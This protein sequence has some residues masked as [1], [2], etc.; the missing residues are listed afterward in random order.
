[1]P[2]MNFK[3]YTDLLRN[4]KTRLETA[5]QNEIVN[6]VRNTGIDISEATIS[7]YGNGDG[8]TIGVKCDIKLEI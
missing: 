2:T 3:D 7:F 8:Q 1:M 4:E 5:I 6:F